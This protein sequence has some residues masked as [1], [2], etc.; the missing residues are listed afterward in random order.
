[1]AHLLDISGTIL[2]Q[3]VGSAIAN[4][5][6]GAIQTPYTVPTEMNTYNT[7]YPLAKKNDYALCLI[8][9]NESH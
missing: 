8:L 7:A 6:Y 4:L 1:M 3:V 5:N 9:K 2:R